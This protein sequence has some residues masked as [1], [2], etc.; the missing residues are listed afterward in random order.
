[1]ELSEARGRLVAIGGG[2][3]KE[4]DA[5]LLK[6]FVKLA[7]GPKARVVVMTVATDDPAGAAAEYR[8]AFRRIGLDDL[9]FVDVSTREDAARPE[10][11]EVIKN[12]TGLFFTG[13]D[14][15]HITS[16]LGG[17]EMQKL[18]HRRHERG[19]V[20]GGTSAGAAMMSN[21]MLISGASDENPKLGGVEIGPGMD[22]LV[23][24]M[25]DTHF[26]QRGRFGRLLTAVA[27]Y[28]QDL[29][30]GIDEQTAMV[31][32]RTEFEVFGSGAVTVIDAGA[33]TYT[34]LPY[35][36]DEKNLSLY[37]V[38]VHVLS[39]G[40][41]FNLAAREPVV[42]EGKFKQSKSADSEADGGPEES[43]PRGRTSG[44]NGGRRTKGK[45]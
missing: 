37:G 33:M 38:R 45:R 3:I 9:Q 30:I 18:I 41:K 21:S 44:K 13:G 20:V 40:H 27:H 4:G 6:E 22:L 31:V 2:E 39:A 26:S 19:L 23:G 8:A 15:L 5:P 34:S 14:Q 1:M 36:E 29:G 25:I 11:L 35:A 43:K 16:L 10:A 24:A 12:A 17:T 7:R 32:N 28:P 42:E